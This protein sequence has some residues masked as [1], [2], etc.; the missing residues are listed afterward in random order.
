MHMHRVDV[1]P[2]IPQ[3]N[4]QHQSSKHATLK[5]HA[6]VAVCGLCVGSTLQCAYTAVNLLHLCVFC[7]LQHHTR[8]WK[9]RETN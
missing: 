3:R 6:N 4:E 9:K 8:S 1:L 5:Q 2:L 7:S